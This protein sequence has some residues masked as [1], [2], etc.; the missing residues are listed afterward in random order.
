MSTAVRPEVSREIFQFGGEDLAK[1]Y[2][3]GHCTAVCSLSGAQ[4]AFP[5]K[6]IRYAQLGLQD[7]LAASLEPWLCYYCGECSQTCPRQAHPG[8]VMMSLRRWLTGQYDVTGLAKRFYLSPRWEFAAL[9]AVAALVVA[10][11]ALFHGPIVTER[12][13]LNTFAPVVWVELGDWLLAATL[14]GLL[15]VNA[16]RM[17]RWTL[18]REALRTIPPGVYFAELRTLV[19]HFLTQKRWRACDSPSRWWKHLVLVGGYLT[20]M[21]LVIVLLRWFQA[22]GSQWRPIDLLGYYATG[23]LLTFSG[24]ALLSRLRHRDEIHKHSHV[25]DWTFLVLLFLTALTGILVHLFRLAGL[26]LPTYAMYVLHL[27]V[28]IPMLVVEVP[29]GKWAHLTYRPLAMYLLAVQQRA[30]QTAAATAPAGAEAAVS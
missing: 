12:V 8:E 22:D 13:E 1:C 3:C 4:A 25:S 5:R 7:K 16:A 9:A 19:V 24:E 17:A 20:M 29:F 15:L 28:A 6:V 30:R 26:A 18:G 11:F 14:G 27:A 23:V 2:N 21:L 10:V